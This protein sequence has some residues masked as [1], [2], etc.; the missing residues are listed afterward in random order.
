MSAALESASATSATT[1]A[2]FGIPAV[3]TTPSSTR[4]RTPSDAKTTRYWVR[5]TA[6]RGTGP[7]SSARERSDMA[8]SG[9]QVDEREDEDPDEVDEAP[10]EAEQLDVVSR[11]PSAQI[12]R[13]D[14]EDVDDPHRHVQPVE[15]GDHVEGV[16]AGGAADREPLAEEPA[17]LAV[18]P[19]EE[20]GAA[21]RGD[22]EERGGRAAAPLRGGRPRH[23][24]RERRADEQEGERGGEPDPERRLSRLHPLRAAAPQDPLRDEQSAEGEAVGDEEDPHPDLARRGRPVL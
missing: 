2:P 10:V 15:A 21:E 1:T 16:G 14:G 7:R 23:H 24:V 9:H 6:P 19:R 12:P 4:V 3:R 22:G 13:E 11:R 17:P 20:E 5:R 8:A 18:L